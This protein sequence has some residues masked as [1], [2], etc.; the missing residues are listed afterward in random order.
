MECLQKPLQQVTWQGFLNYIKFFLLLP[1]FF[2]LP[3][4]MTSSV[5]PLLLLNLYWKLEEKYLL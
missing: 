5:P 4:E 3:T 1:F 2:F